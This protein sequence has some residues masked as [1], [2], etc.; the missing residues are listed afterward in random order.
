MLRAF[1]RVCKGLKDGS[2][3]GGPALAPIAYDAARLDCPKCRAR[4]SMVAHGSYR[5]HYVSIDQG[6]VSDTLIEVLRLRCASCKSTHALMPP[7]VIPYCVFSLCFI[8]A[9]ICDRSSHRFSSIET[10]C[11][12]YEI[13][14]S[15]FYRMSRRFGACVRLASG[16]CADAFDVARIARLL[17]GRYTDAADGLLSGFFDLCATSFC[18]S[19]SP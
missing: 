14:I 15:T 16:A 11:A 8:A 3:D 2:E 1:K 4:R 6:V 7:T 10:L 19:R 5:R 12:H 13:A 17:K 18:Q 9:L